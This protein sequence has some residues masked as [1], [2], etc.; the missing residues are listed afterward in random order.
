MLRTSLKSSV[1]KLKTFSLNLCAL[2]ASDAQFAA[3][4]RQSI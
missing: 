1:L 2:S 3:R 4:G